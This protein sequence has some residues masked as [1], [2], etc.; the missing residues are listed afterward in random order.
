MKK[1]I[2]II[3][4]ILLLAGGMIL[5][6][7][8]QQ[9]IANAPVAA[10][11]IS[12]VQTVTPQTKTIRQTRT[13]L[14]KLESEH[15]VSLSSKLSGRINKVMVKESQR[16]EQGELLV[17]IDDRELSADIKALQATLLSAQKDHDY[18]RGLYERN[19]VLFEAGGLAREKL[20]AS[21]AVSLAKKSVVTST[22]QKI[23]ALES[24]LDYLAI[25]A[26]FAGII[27]TIFLHQ[28][29]LA[30]A[31]RPLL[32]LNSL[33]QKL[34]F[35]FAHDANEIIPGQ[36]VELKEG[37]TGKITTLYNDASDGLS[38]AEI[39]LAKNLDLPNGSYLTIHVVTRVDTGCALPVNAL[40]HGV[41][42]ESVMVYVKDHF[43]PLLVT[44]KARG[45]EF[46]LIEPCVTSPV[47]VASEAKLS[48]LPLYGQIRIMPGDRNE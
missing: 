3:L 39:A 12:T 16:V 43:E 28:G 7:K 13:F 23:R 29:D 44:V 40:L 33:Q 24:R 46:V 15:S 45:N 5:I 14:A 34:T 47:A 48:L 17:Q 42:G 31:G 32:S 38:V 1:I 35:R 30:T 37:K 22:K 4:L 21:E 9:S 11:L 6:K 10:P 26:P 41:Q 25:K 27:G 20:E 19:I 18:N 36:N 2:L 8:R